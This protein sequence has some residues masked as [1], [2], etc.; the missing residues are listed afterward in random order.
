M[1]VEFPSVESAAISNDLL[2]TGEITASIA[3]EPPTLRNL[4]VV[5]KD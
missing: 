2:V 4:D 5:R 1:S 3:L